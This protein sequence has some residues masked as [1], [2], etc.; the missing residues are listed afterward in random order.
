MP[1]ASE[2][3]FLFYVVKDNLVKV[4][5]TR[6]I[7]YPPAGAIPQTRCGFTHA[8]FFHKFIAAVPVEE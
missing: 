8:Q 7:K 5:N 6:L 4:T 2:K 1:C 3:K